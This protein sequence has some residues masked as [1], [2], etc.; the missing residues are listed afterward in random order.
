[1]ETMFWLFNTRGGWLVL[2]CLI[3]PGV[4]AMMYAMKAGARQ[5]K[6]IDAEDASMEMMRRRDLVARTIERSDY[7]GMSERDFRAWMELNRAH[8]FPV[9]RDAMINA[10]KAKYEEKPKNRLEPYQN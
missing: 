8:I 5:Q 4:V 7:I 6:R 9:E 2:A 10:R 3:V 1:M